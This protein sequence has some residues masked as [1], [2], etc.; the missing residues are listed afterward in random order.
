MSKITLKI[1]LHSVKIVGRGIGRGVENHRPSLFNGNLAEIQLYC[2]L[3][4]KQHR[5][6]RYGG[7]YQIMLLPKSV[8]CNSFET[9]SV[10]LHSMNV[11]IQRRHRRGARSQAR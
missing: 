10:I 3:K 7:S 6:F 8:L 4:I 9:T 11:Q 2:K 1:E 5:T